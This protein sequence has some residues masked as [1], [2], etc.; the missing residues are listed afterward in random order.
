[1]NTE[2]LVGTTLGG[3][4]EVLEKIGTGGMASVFKAKDNL[5]NRFVA[6]KVLK[7]NLEGEEQVVSN[8][9]REA[10]S[11]A[12]LVH[13]NIVSVYDV[14]EEDGMNYMVME[15]VDG[16]TLKQYIR[17]NGA[18]PWQEAC[19]YAIQ[20][21]Q[22][23]SEA[24]AK[25]IIH[26]DIKPQN[27]IMTQDKTLKVTDFG[28]AKAAAAD[29]TIVG[30]TA[31]GS[32]H[33]ISPEQ[34][35]GG[36]TDAR[37]DIYSLGIVLYEMLTG[38][39]PFDGDTPVSVA[40]MHLEKE[41]IDVKCVNMDIPT[42]LAYVTMK[43]IEKEQKNRYSNVQEMLNDLHAVLAEEPLPSKEDEELSEESRDELE[44]RVNS[45][46]EYDSYN[47]EADEASEDEPIESEGRRVRTHKR[48]KVRKQKTAAQKKEDRLAVVLAFGTIAAVILIVFGAYKIINGVKGSSVPNLVNMTVEEATAELTKAKLKPADEIE[49]SLSDD[50]EE[51]R[52]VSQEPGANTFLAKGSAV[53]L[54]VSIGPSGGN[55]QAPQ[56][57]GQTFD[58][59]ISNIL[60]SG[61]TYEVKEEASDKV[62]ANRVI[63][64][65]PIAGTMLN[66]NDIITIHVS[67]GK[68]NSATQ[69]PSAVQKVRVP[70]VKGLGREQAE[71]VLAKHGLSLGAVTKRP[72]SMEANLII[73]QSPSSDTTVAKGTSVSIVLSSGNES[74][75]QTGDESHQNFYGQNI[76]EEK[77]NDN[78]ETGSEQGSGS[79]TD[80]SEP[81]PDPTQASAGKTKTFTVKIPDSAGDTVDVEIV[82]NGETVHSGT[83]K[84]SEGYVSAEITGEGTV[85]VQAYVD[86]ALAAQK[87]IVF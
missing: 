66:A 8:F 4:Y 67:T 53:K 28:I 59:A 7:D 34:A 70:D 54:V 46:D 81:E 11:S 10:Q 36:Y 83:H 51:G 62:E 41:P 65:T 12:S 35:R 76:D 73:S 64:Q 21:G 14:G 6:I 17:E 26:R 71:T 84:K 82:A 40:L 57:V 15:L 79:N 50:I 37:S 38:K 19:D 23:I 48:K 49:Y 33:Y 18:L 22:G 43:A 27:I 31:L 74:S 29:T 39:V 60:A 16:I 42:D 87:Q 58:E 47:D 68:D 72:S 9:I 78:S 86:G 69:A 56:T 52:V 32:V 80:Q 25:N 63:R 24:H 3:R 1:M 85:T 61:L 5:L 2:N 77:N 20:I 75:T 45:E 30:G 13:N 44:R 55:I